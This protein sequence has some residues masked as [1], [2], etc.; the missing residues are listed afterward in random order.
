MF[1]WKTIGRVYKETALVMWGFMLAK[2][3]E[4]KATIKRL[5]ESGAHSFP[6]EA[7]EAIASLVNF[8]VAAGWPA[9][10]LWRVYTLM[11]SGAEFEAQVEKAIEALERKKQE[12][13]KGTN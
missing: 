1:N 10:L 4:T 5:R 9:L 11:R 6:P 8:A 3:D 2:S 7:D 13:S 12:A